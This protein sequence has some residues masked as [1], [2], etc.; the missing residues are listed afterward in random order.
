MRASVDGAAGAGFFYNDCAEP[1]QCGLESVPDP[2]CED[3]ACRV[4]ESGDVVEVVVIELLVQRLERGLE[5]GEVADPANGFIYLAAQMDLHAEGMAVQPSAS[6]AGWNIG[7]LV[8][9][10]EAKFFE[11]LHLFQV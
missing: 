1:R 11:D 6:V 9:C 3:F 10:L 2:A 7:Q 8:S 5:V 4:L